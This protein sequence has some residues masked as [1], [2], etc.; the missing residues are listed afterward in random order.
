[1]AVLGKVVASPGGLL[2]RAV[3]VVAATESDDVVAITDALGR[4]TPGPT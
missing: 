3:D 1:M 4:V 2:Q